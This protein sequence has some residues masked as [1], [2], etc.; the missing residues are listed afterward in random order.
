MKW[1]YAF[2]GQQ[3]GPITTEQLKYLASSGTITPETLVWRQGFGEQWRPAAQAGIIFTMSQGGTVEGSKPVSDKW[4][5]VFLIV[6][7]VLGQ[8]FLLVLDAQHLSQQ[9]MVRASLSGSIIILGISLVIFLADRTVLR[10]AGYR[11]PNGWWFLLT[12]GYFWARLQVLGRGKALLWVSLLILAVSFCENI[13]YSTQ[14]HDNPNSAHA[15]GAPSAPD[16]NGTA[17][18]DEQENL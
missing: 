7:W 18:G 3:V 1:Y 2:E 13:Y 16:Q 4:A 9:Q 15:A 8:I 5:W 14:K 10:D 12:P 17:E 6:P 11:P